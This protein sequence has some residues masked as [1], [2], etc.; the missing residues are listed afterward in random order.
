MNT[1]SPPRAVLFGSIGTLAET[2]DLQRRAFNAAFAEAGLPWLWDDE[3]YRRLLQVPGGAARIA[4]YAADQGREVDAAALHARKRVLFH[5]TLQAVDLP[6]RPGVT[7]ILDAAEEAGAALALV[8][9]TSAETV[10]H[11][12][13]ALRPR[14][15]PTT[16]D[17]ITTADDGLP[18]KPHP[19]AYVHAL[20][21]LGMAREDAVALEDSPESAAAAL[22]AGLRTVAMPGAAHAGRPFGPVALVTP[23]PVP[24]D[25]GLTDWVSVD[26]DTLAAFLGE[27]R[28]A[29]RTGR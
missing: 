25:L 10:L 13:E 17:V 28:A 12:L 21:R 24:A 26:D 3:V 2:S 22:G 18:P 4:A 29:P 20:F 6:P 8:T 14:L 7:D 11:L 23:R 9:T 1:S 16:F 15:E 27:D 5:E 19:A